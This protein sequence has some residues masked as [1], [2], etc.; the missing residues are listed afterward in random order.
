MIDSDTVFHFVS[1]AG[2]PA[3]I[4]DDVRARIARPSDV[5]APGELRPPTTRTILVAHSAGAGRALRLAATHPQRVAGIIAVSGVVPRP[6]TTFLGALP[7]PQR[8]IVDVAMRL[9]GTKPPA[10]AIRATLAEGLPSTLVDRIVAD[11]AA[12]PDTTF[13][14]PVP[15]PPTGIP[16]LY[17]ATARDREFP[18]A[19]QRVF[20]QNLGA[21]VDVLPTGHLPMLEQPAA[22]AEALTT[23]ARRFLD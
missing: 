7:Y 21:P 17:L 15:A 13:R 10:S 1:G 12:E 9:A 20:A 18:P 23:A 16:S 19:R 5:A 2:L 14:M 22:L 3:W 6:G 4:W 8:L 11:I